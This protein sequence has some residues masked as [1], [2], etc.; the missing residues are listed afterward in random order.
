MRF[1]CKF[2]LLFATKLLQV[3]VTSAF[4]GSKEQKQANKRPVHV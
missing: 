4:L 2:P 3:R 1:L